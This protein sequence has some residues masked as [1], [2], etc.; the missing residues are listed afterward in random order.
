MLKWPLKSMLATES[1]YLFSIPGLNQ[2][3]QE[4]STPDFVPTDAQKVILEQALRHLDLELTFQ[5]DEQPELVEQL[6]HCLKELL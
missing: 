6:N 3:S 1:T 2:L 5:A 4:L